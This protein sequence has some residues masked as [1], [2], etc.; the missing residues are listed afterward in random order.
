MSF[1]TESYKKRLLELSGLNQLLN[2]SVSGKHLVVVDVQPEYQSAFGDMAS[3]L[4]DFINENYHQLSNLTFLYNGAD[5]LGMID[6]SS[7]KSWWYEQGLDEDVLISANFYD[8]GYAF[9]RYCMDEGIDEEQIVNLVKH[10]IENNINDSRELTKDFWDEFIQ[11]YGNEDIRELIEFSDDCIS[12]PDLM[13]EL[14]SYYNIVLCGGGI[15]ECLKEV[16]IAL[17][18]LNKTYTTFDRFTY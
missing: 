10:M 2:E 1:L 9:F 11:K 18:A 15:N 3:D 8:K 13:D 7:Y 12:I 16:E 5:T 14:S 17:D 4:A 6:E